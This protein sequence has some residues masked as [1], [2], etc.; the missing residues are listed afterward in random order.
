MF[1]FLY[2]GVPTI[3]VELSGDQKGQI[4]EAV[5]ARVITRAGAKGDADILD[6]IA[7]SL[8][9]LYSGATRMAQ[10]KAGKAFIDGKGADRIAAAI[11]ERCN[12]SI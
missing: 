3:V 2:L 4:G 1:E 8:A 6:N 7:E 5:S 9:S 12:E 10:S 11:E